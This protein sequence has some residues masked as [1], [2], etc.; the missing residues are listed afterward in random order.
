[1]LKETTVDPLDA[2]TGERLAFTPL[3][4][5]E[6]MVDMHLTLERA[7]NFNRTVECGKV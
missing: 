5:L 3:E 1:M 2:T 7:S 6:S 4:S